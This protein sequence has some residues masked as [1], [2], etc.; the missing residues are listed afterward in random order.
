MLQLEAQ[1]RRHQFVTERSVS[2]LYQ[3]P[4]HKR[5]WRKFTAFMER[6][7]HNLPVVK[8]GGVLIVEASKQSVAPIS[9]LR[10]TVKRPLKALEGMA[11]PVPGTAGA[12]GVPRTKNDT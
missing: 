1:L 7:G 8:A 10:E 5:I 9:G 3:P 11:A 2:A 6:V 12:R 4:S